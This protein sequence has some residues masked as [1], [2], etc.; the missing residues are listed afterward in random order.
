MLAILTPLTDSSFR[1][2]DSSPATSWWRTTRVLKMPVKLTS[3]P[4]SWSTRMRPPPV[5]AAWRT[6]FLPSALSTASTAVLGWASRRWMVWKRNSSP[7]PTAI[8]KLSGMPRSSGFIPRSPATRARSVPWPCPVSAKEPWRPISAR[9]GAAPSSVLAM[10][11]IRTA[12]A[13]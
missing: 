1:I 2:R 4:S 5:E 13:V 8:S 12:P 3:T 7:C 9:T 6:S 11:P 10:R